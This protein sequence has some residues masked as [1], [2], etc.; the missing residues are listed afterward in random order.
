MVEPA[1]R[2]AAE[3]GSAT[4]DFAAFR[5][6]SY[7]SMTDDESAASRYHIPSARR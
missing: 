5:M 2:V 4:H 6:E 3:L 7:G 1:S